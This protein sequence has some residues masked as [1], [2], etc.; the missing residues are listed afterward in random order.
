MD[1]WHKTWGKISSYKFESLYEGHITFVTTFLSTTTEPE[2]TSLTFFS[3]NKNSKIF[4]FSLIG[5]RCG[6]A[7]ILTDSMLRNE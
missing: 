7:I 2:R 6:G 5:G 3:L 1:E 4:N